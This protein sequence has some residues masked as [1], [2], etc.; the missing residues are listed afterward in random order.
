M[1]ALNDDRLHFLDGLRGWGALAV[2]IFHVFIDGFPINDSVTSRL[3]HVFVFN[4][5]LAV[6]IF[7]LVSG[8]SLSIAFCQR[9]DRSSLVAIAIGRLP[10]LAIPVFCASLLLY[11]FFAV[12]AVPAA[13]QRLPVFQAFLPVAPSLW[14][15]VRSSFFDTFFAFSPSTT[16]IPPLWTMPFELW[17]SCLVLGASLVA[18]Q[19]PR[20]FL[21][22]GL[23]T[24]LA[25]FVHQIYA[26]FMMGLLLAEF[27]AAG[28]WKKNA[29]RIS[30]FS[31]LGF[32]ASIY[33]AAVLPRAGDEHR[34]AYLAVAVAMTVSCIFSKPLSS[35][36]SS[37]LSRFLGRISFPL[38]LIHGPVMLAYGNNAYRWVGEPT[39]VQKA[40]LNLSM[41]AL[42][43]TCA[44]FLIPTDRWG[45]VAAKRF[46]TYVT[47]KRLA[48][49]EPEAEVNP[50][51]R[52]KSR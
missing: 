10:R 18:G 34:N 20:R 11:V 5:A 40:L 48:P 44:I 17:G 24:L 30:V 29:S 45:I 33:A 28:A 37:S 19:L 16:L 52:Y 46:S 1:T 27:Y 51:E 9:R 22:Y 36:L 26:A 50:L 13:T 43:I 47:G 14:E 8:F 6:W 7:F 31:T 41:V 25:Y 49:N 2:V 12:G 23:L 42:S 32:C 35:M 21:V 38:Y 4:G 3:W 39:D 15:V